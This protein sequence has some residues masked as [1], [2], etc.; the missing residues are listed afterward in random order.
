M[1]IV[2]PIT[3]KNTILTKKL[4]NFVNLISQIVIFI[5]SKKIHFVILVLTIVLNKINFFVNFV[6]TNSKY[7]INFY[8]SN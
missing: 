1:G 8:F 5:Y 3:A 7:V 2:R 6:V 4:V